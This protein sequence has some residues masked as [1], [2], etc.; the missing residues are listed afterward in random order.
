[1]MFQ[2]NERRVRRSDDL[3]MALQYLLTAQ[4]ERAGLTHILL[5]SLDGML[6]ACDGERTECEELAAYAPIIAEGRGFALDP[7]RLAGVS[8]HR[9]RVGRE[10]LLLL[11]RGEMPTERIAGALMASIDGVVRIL[12]S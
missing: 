7:R 3:A 1:M 9:F 11:L 6:L 10:D 4:R 5:A 12:G 2:T 8:V